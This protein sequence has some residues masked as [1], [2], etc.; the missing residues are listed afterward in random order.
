MINTVRKKITFF[1][2]APSQEKLC[3][4][5]MFSIFLP[6]LVT[7]AVLVVTFFY[8]L[9][10]PNY[11][12]KVLHADGAK[13]LAVFCIPLFLSPLFEKHLLGLAAGAGVLILLTIGLWISRVMKHHIF[14]NCLNIAVVMSIP[15]AMVA[16]AQKLY[17]FINPVDTG[18]IYRS[19][20][21]FMNPN[22]Y[23][24]II[25]F[26][27]LICL[28]KFLSNRQLNRRLF[29]AV[30]LGMNYIALYLSNSFSAC[31]AIGIAAAALLL[32]NRRFKALG[33]VM[34]LGVVIVAAVLLFPGILPRMSFVEETCTIRMHIWGQA[35]NGFLQSP[36]LGI[37][38][39][40]YWSYSSFETYNLLHQPHAHNILLDLLLNYGLIGTVS[41]A[42][43]LIK[44]Y[45][46][47]LKAAFAAKYKPIGAFV[48]AVTVSVLTHGITD[49]T[50]LWHQ[51][52]LL[53]LFLL[54]G[55]SLVTNEQEAE[56]A[57]R[58]TS[59]MQRGLAGLNDAIAIRKQVFME[60]QGF[61][62]E[63]DD[64]D[65]VA[66]HVVLYDDG[67]PIATGRTFLRDG[68]FIIG[69]VAVCREYRRLHIGSIVIEKLEEKIEQL[70]GTE[71]RLSAQLQA[72]GFYEK[73]GYHITSGKYH[74]E[75]HCPH[76]E[77]VKSL[78]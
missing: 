75:E 48:G 46:I 17:F 12:D 44:Q 65:P 41:F 9:F 74:Y 51:T 16:Y 23:G 76:V 58:I 2:S 55:V 8:I 72:Q 71:A 20:S 7:A 32:F 14:E 31:A 64:I 11:R 56:S 24:G 6:F 1:R 39:L 35:F 28:Y 19:V 29:Y 61:A 13:W 5:L 43:I 67:K 62:E 78:S 26:V 52:G 69:R 21:F 15:C 66:W 18:N 77:M 4:F 47:H 59:R 70:G 60:E 30:V 57:L 40:G 10:K 22:Y 49:V 42:M 73:L 25:E 38:T 33:A 3:Y 68:Q 63:F 54:S 50:V 34:G 37:G 53:L 45:G 36:L 27:S